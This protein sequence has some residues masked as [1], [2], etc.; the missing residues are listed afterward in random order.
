M[1]VLKQNVVF[2]AGLASFFVVLE[3]ALTVSTV[4][5][6]SSSS[7]SPLIMPLRARKTTL[8]TRRGAGAGVSGL[9]TIH[10][11]GNLTYWGEYFTSVGLGTPPQFLNLQVDTGSTDLICF[12]KGC[13]GCGKN[14]GFYDEFKSST[15]SEIDCDDTDYN[16][17]NQCQD[18]L[19]QCQFLNQYGDGSS[20]GGN[21]MRDV[22][23]IGNYTTGDNTVVFGA[24]NNVDAPNGFEATGVDG[25][26]GFAFQSLS[27][28][29]GSSAFSTLVGIYNF[30]DG[31][32]MCLRPEGGVLEL[33]VDYSKNS[34]FKWTPITDE[35]WY[36][37]DI[38]DILVGETSI[39][40]SWWDLNWNGVI[41]DSGTTLLI[42]P[43]DIF[44]AIQT[45]FTNL[46]SKVKLA[47]ICGLPANETL[48]AGQ[49][50]NMTVQQVKQFPTFSINFYQLGP[51]PIQPIDY[52]WQGTGIPG[53]YCMGIQA[54]DNLPIIIGDV[55][56]Q[57]YHVVFDKN[58]DKIGFGPISTCPKI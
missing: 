52:L 19:S 29:G 32:A 16:C 28:W 7:S 33:G 45:V 13:T 40:F 55:F 22:L 11:T 9:G 39:G 3:A 57:R 31:F 47:G 37:V 23:V 27:S 34:N 46:C 53:Q 54:M 35:E 10:L 15:A 2:L 30:Y 24:I 17:A 50:Y 38:E 42:V 12:A 21:L 44:G 5:S 14:N 26:I 48:F 43:S 41:V 51:L 18:S 4:S 6:A 58:T 8:L 1:P 56:M 49:C 36:G 25:I 20:I